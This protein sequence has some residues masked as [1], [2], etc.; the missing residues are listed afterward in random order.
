M[1]EN[2]NFKYPNSDNFVL[3]D[4]NLELNAGNTYCIYGASGSG[5]TTFLNV[6]MN[7]LT[8]TSGKILVNS[9][10]NK[11]NELNIFSKISYL[12]QYMMDSLYQ[13]DTH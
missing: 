5:K 10:N 7:F 9:N 2:L 13:K 8:P 1:I 4:M 3:K 11:L 6:L 12:S